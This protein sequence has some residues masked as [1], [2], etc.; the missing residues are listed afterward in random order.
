[1]PTYVEYEAQAVDIIKEAKTQFEEGL[2]AL[3]SFGNESAVLLNLIH[4]SGEDIPI[5][6][7]DTGFWMPETRQHQRNLQ[8]RLGFTA[9]RYRPDPATRALIKAERLWET[10]L[11]EYNQL[12]KLEP[13]T[14]AVKELGITALLS[15]VRSAQN[16][17]RS[18]LST[19]GIGND[20]EW[21]IHPV[22]DWPEEV[23][24]AY[25]EAENLPR[26]PLQAQGY[27]S[28]GDWTITRP[29]Q[30]REGRGLGAKSECGLHVPVVE[31]AVV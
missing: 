7:I 23:V 25:F 12:T 10:D 4:K 8:E 28:I 21:R 6:T 13:L 2:Y 20:N 11:D 15:G 14:R 3:S 30:G 26:H 5:V 22:I 24:E 19:Y 17:N 29:G 1:M 9:L 31:R 16:D 18:N 27:G